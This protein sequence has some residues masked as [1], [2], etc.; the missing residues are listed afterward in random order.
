MLPASTATSFG[1]GILG[2][3][4]VWAGGGQQSAKNLLNLFFG[5]LVFGQ[6]SEQYIAQLGAMG[7]SSPRKLFRAQFKSPIFRNFSLN[8][9]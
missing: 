6:R 7:N 3:G 8:S 2:R 9:L 1:R 5:K 4:V